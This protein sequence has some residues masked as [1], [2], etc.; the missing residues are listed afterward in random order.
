MEAQSALSSAAQ[1]C[2]PTRFVKELHLQEAVQEDVAEFAT[3][4]LEYLAK[5]LAAAGDEPGR[6]IGELFEGRTV[7]ALSSA[8]QVC[9][10]TRFVKELSG[11]SG[12]STVLVFTCAQHSIAH[13]SPDLAK[14]R[15]KGAKAS[16]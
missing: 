4:F 2:D 1:V 12:W 11:S 16:C 8:V 9:D 5:Q 10:P 6:W 15:A 14:P 13:R 7:L 3:L